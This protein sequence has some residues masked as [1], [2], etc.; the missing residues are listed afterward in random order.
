MDL[1]FPR[2]PFPLASVCRRPRGETLASGQ[3]DYRRARSLA[4]SQNAGLRIAWNVE[5]LAQD[6]GSEDPR[7]CQHRMPRRGLKRFDE[8]SRH[9]SLSPLS[10]GVSL[11]AARARHIEPGIGVAYE[12]E[13]PEP[14]ILKATGRMICFVRHTL[15]SYLVRLTGRVIRSML[16]GPAEH[17]MC[18]HPRPPL[19]PS[20][21]WSRQ[22]K[23][24]KLAG[25]ATALRDWVSDDMN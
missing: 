1:L 22:A 11:L 17:R 14:A 7:P 5:V 13:N 25:L 19:M 12:P 2:S 24:S 8:C 21:K 23:K 4:D 3:G 9:Q 6:L 18:T 10:N 16:A 20:R 15:R